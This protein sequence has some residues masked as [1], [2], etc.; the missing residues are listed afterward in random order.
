MT[1]KTTVPILLHVHSQKTYRLKVHIKFD[2]KLDQAALILHLSSSGQMQSEFSDQNMPVVR[3][4]RKT[5][6]HMC[7]KK[8]QTKVLHKR[9]Q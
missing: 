7:T 6:T 2:M 4:C 3:R 8:L 1:G 9:N 5:S